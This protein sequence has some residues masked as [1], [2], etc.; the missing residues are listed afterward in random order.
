MRPVTPT[1]VVP[2]I[3]NQYPGPTLE[4]RV[5]DYVRITVVNRL[6]EP[7]AVHWHG[8]KQK[9]T[10]WADGVPYVSQCPISPGSSYVY[11]FVLDTP[12]TLW[13]HSHYEL[14][15]SSL[16]GGIIVHGDEEALAQ[17]YGM[18]K[19][20]LLLLNDWYHNSSESQ[21][22]GLDKRLPKEFVWVGDAQS[23]LFN[24]RGQANCSATKKPCNLSHPDA[25][26]FILTVK[27]G[28]TYRLRIVGASA[29][30]F[31]NFFIDKHHLEL[32][33]ADTQPLV[34][35]TTTYLDVGQGQSFSA[36]L[37][38]HTRAQL[39]AMGHDGNFWMQTNVRHRT[40]GA[41]GLAVLR[42]ACA[43]K[44]RLPT[45]PTPATWPARNDTNWSLEHARR[46]KAIGRVSQSGRDGR[47]PKPTRRFVYLGTQ[48]RI[49]D[50]R[51]VWALNN[52]SYEQP[53][54]PVLQALATKKTS[55]TDAW[56]EQTSVPTPYDYNLTLAQ[57]N[58]S[59]IARRETQ[60]VRVRKGEVVEF[61]FQ[62]TRSLS[63]AP[64]IHPWHLHLHNVWVMGFG[65][66]G[67]TWSKSD[68]ASYDTGSAVHRNTF[69]L[70]P[71]SWTAVRVRFDNA[72][73]ALFHCHI[74]SHLHMGM[75]FVVA[76]GDAKD[77]PCAP[78]GELFCGAGNSATDVYLQAPQC[79]R[80]VDKPALGRST[81]KPVM[82]FNSSATSVPVRPGR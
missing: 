43:A 34:P 40:S 9:G 38:T 16:Y 11:S 36:I 39:D 44:P 49:P 27:P 46:F 30:S 77:V 65:E 33:E 32:V 17:R 45:L 15:K 41:T 63:G 6:T 71:Q 22:E 23:L 7:T 80:H 18:M 57:A 75:G 28:T 24:G 19:E 13:W 82:A 62:N 78:K 25:G 31:L 69:M 35:F 8:V 29:L 53:A 72:G 4:G 21:I 20:K 55:A 5:G 47:V 76:I 74:I 2:V 64:E 14:Q 68:I 3:N 12:G 58:L 50:G 1:Q 66:P 56:V 73:A 51:L 79:R 26:P 42:Y 54:T 37:R 81:K 59:I 48:N 10:P 70:Y 67:T 60:V 61:V 52:I